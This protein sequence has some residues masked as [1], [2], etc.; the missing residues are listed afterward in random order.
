MVQ[1]TTEQRAFT[2]LRAALRCMA[3]YS[4]LKSG[5]DICDQNILYIDIFIEE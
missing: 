1:L 3:P 2:V 4:F 5:K